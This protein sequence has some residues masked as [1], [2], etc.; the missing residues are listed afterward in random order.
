M[1]DLL[2]VSPASTSTNA[3]N[4]RVKRRKVALGAAIASGALVVLALPLYLPAFWLQLG[5]T[6]C[7]LA[8]GTIGLSMLAGTG[9]LSLGMPFFMAIGALTYVTLASA[10][11]PESGSV[12]M[13]W[14]PALAIVAAVLASGA[15]GLLFSPIAARL[16]GIYLAM[17]SFGLVILAEHIFNNAVPLSGGYQGRRTPDF[18]LF[19][20]VFGRSADP[21]MVL[22]VPFGRQEWLWYL[23]VACVAAVV[24]FSLNVMRSRPGRALKL[25]AAGELSASAG[26]VHV[27]AYRARL[28]CLSSMYAGL[29]GVLFALSIGSIAPSSFNVELALRTLAIIVIGGMGS[30]GG[31]VAGTAFVVCLPV[32]LQPALAGMT[33][34]ESADVSTAQL[35]RYVYGAAII[36]VLLFWPRGFAG[37]WGSLTAVLRRRRTDRL[38]RQE[39]E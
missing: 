22:G 25:I 28:F 3:P 17:A 4:R 34:L 38:T 35:S 2:E 36:A 39:S 27:T 31:A 24:A 12:G 8:V 33:F 16:K 21:V 6:V 29:S 18:E 26:G 10:S 13:G 1:S 19:G 9:Q 32:L 11:D 20:I 37:L 30:I 15:A 5:F 7:A 14:P 23:G